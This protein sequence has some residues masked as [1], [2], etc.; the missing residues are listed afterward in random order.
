[1]GV[2]VGALPLAYLD[3]DALLPQGGQERRQRLG[4]RPVVGQAR[5]VVERDDVDVR[6]AAVQQSGQGAAVP[7]G[8]VEAAQQDVLVGHLPTRLGEEVVGRVQDG[9]QAGLVVGR[10]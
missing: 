10:H 8:V 1:G 2:D 4:R 6:L 9:R 7:G 5:H 3:A